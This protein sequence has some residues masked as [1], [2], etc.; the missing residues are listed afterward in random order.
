MEELG[1]VVETHH[2]EV[3]TAGQAEIDMRFAPIVDMADQLM[4]YKYV[5]QERRAPRRQGRDVHAEAALR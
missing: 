5:V 4:V 3:A 2:H 1:I